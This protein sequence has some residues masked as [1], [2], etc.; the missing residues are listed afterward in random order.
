MVFLSVSII[1]ERNFS[2]SFQHPDSGTL[3]MAEIVGGNVPVSP[4]KP[5]ARSDSDAQSA[6]GPFSSGVKAG[7]RGKKSH[8]RA[9]ETKIL[10]L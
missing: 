9:K 10:V 8:G 1:V 4:G 2:E 3:Q 6:G 5:N 7:K